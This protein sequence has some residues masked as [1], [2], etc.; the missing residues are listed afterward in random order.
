[1]TPLPS[2]CTSCRI[3]R[4]CARALPEPASDASAVAE[5]E[6]EPLLET[7][8]VA[9]PEVL[10]TVWVTASARATA[11]AVPPNPLPVAFASAV[12]SMEELLVLVISPVASSWAETLCVMPSAS[13]FAFA[14]PAPPSALA[15]AL[16]STVSVPLF[17]TVPPASPSTLA[18]CCVMPS[19]SALALADSPSASAIAETS[20]LVVEVMLPVASPEAPTLLVTIWEIPLAVALA[21]PSQALNWPSAEACAKEE[22]TPLSIVPSALALVPLVPTTCVM[23]SDAAF[24]FAVL[25]VVGCALAKDEAETVPLELTVPLALPLALKTFWLIASA[26]AMELALVPSVSAVALTLIVPLLPLLTVP[27]A[28]VWPV[29][30]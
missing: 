9:L 10:F 26:V 2:A 14:M 27:V 1:M 18:T 21:S 17:S 23:P 12:T 4:D 30:S 25:P 28:P 6:I 15:I 5:A 20:R 16:A 29:T 8:P 13:A 3:P 24:A 19:A 11:F 22:S 7:V